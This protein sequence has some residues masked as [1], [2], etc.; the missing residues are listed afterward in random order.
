MAPAV[1]PLRSAIAGIEV[2][3]S[4]HTAAQFAQFAA[5]ARVYGLLASCGSD[6]HGP[7]ESFMDLGDLP[8]LPAG[9]TPVWAS[10]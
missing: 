2:L 9:I 4:A 10:W 1:M 7:G 6:Y 5:L 3:A 8:P